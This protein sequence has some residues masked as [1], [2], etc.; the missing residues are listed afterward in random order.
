MFF[1]FLIQQQLIGMCPGM[2][3]IGAEGFAKYFDERVVNEFRERVLTSPQRETQRD[4]RGRFRHR[5][6][7]RTGSLPQAEPT[8]V[9]H[10]LLYAVSKK[11]LV[12][13]YYGRSYE[14]S[15]ASGVR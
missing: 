13:Q 6:R 12:L 10:L 4:M 5:F 14:S 1:A 9:V 11:F 7:P 3:T 15:N 8:R 2:R